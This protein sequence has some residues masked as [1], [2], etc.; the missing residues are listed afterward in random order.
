MSEAERERAEAF[1][2]MSEGVL[3]KQVEIVNLL[4]AGVSYEEL[5]KRGFSEHDIESVRMYKG[6]TQKL[7]YVLETW[8]RHYEIEDLG[9]L[10][11]AFAT[12]VSQGLP[13]D[14]IW[15]MLVGPPSTIKS[16][17]IRAFGEDATER[18]WPLSTLTVNTFISG[19]DKKN[20]LLRRL[21]GKV[22]TVKDLTTI[23]EKNKDT[24]NEIFS[25]LR[26]IYDGYF[27]KGTGNQD[28]GYQNIKA[29]I[30]IIAGATSVIDLYESAQNLL[31]SR[32]VKVRT[33]AGD[34]RR[35]SAKARRM[36]GKETE[37]RKEVG[38]ITRSYLNSVKVAEVPTDDATHELLTQLADFV[39]R[40]RTGIPR[41]WY[42]R[43]EYLPEP[44]GIPRLYKQ[45]LKLSWCLSTIL[46][47]TN[48]DNDVLRLI[49]KVGR[50][51][52]DSRRLLVLES[53]PKDEERTSVVSARVGLPG[54][55]TSRILEDLRLL[56]FAKKGGDE[57]KGYTWS[58]V[59]ESLLTLK[60]FD[61][62]E[63]ANSGG[64]GLFFGEGN[65][66]GLSLYPIFKPN[67]KEVS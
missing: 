59:D 39:C 19:Q 13:G 17:V 30:T 43:V 62:L 56:G 41:D 45:F 26:E 64:L 42:G 5:E 2:E 27:S 50:D 1:E 44:E 16:E 6:E 49:A 32:F 33:H 36:A 55:T 34:L 23:L 60:R 61:N 14:P 37:V 65:T 22:V 31:G 48:V 25:Q 9:P 18:V 54:E 24:R 28:A 7:P 29:R 11:I 35:T 4:K 57:N 46:D 51:T 58:L 40:M 47:R 63:K 67:G 52:I 20:S 8:Q 21:D 10:L 53:L 66:V 38:Q 15:L 12:Y 3:E